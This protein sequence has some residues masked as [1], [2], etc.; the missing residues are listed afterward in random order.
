VSNN[1]VESL[2]R[3]AFLVMGLVLLFTG[4]RGLLGFAIVLPTKS[5]GLQRFTGRSARVA[6]GVAI[7]FG[8]LVLC[9]SYLTLE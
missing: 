9:F 3:I 4:I 1:Q 2:F 7:F 6:G 5:R 8:A